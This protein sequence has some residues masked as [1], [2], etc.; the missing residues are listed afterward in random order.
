MAY[1]FDVVHRLEPVHHYADLR[2]GL[3]AGVADP[4]WFLGRQW[5]LGEH[6][7]ED[8]SSPVHVEYRASLTPINPFDRNERLDPQRVPAEAIV[9]GEPGEFWTPGRRVTIGRAVALAAAEAGRPP[10]ADEERL[11][12]SGLP[13]PY[14]VLDGTGFDG[15]ALFARRRDLELDDEWFPERPPRPAPRDLWDSA[16][17]VYSADFT[18]GQT[19]LSLRRHDGG[20]LDWWSVD[21]TAPIP[22]PGRP[23][24]PARV[25]ATRIRYPGAPNPRWWQ[26]EESRTDLGTYAPDRSHFATLLLL[27]LVTSHSDDWFTFPVAAAAGHVV[28][29]HEVVVVDDFGDRW[30]LEPPSD[31]WSLFA[32]TGLGPN[33]LVLWPSVTTPL[34]GPVLDQ[35]DLGVDEDANLVWAVE[36]RVDGRDNPTPE[37]PPEPVASAAADQDAQP[38]YAYRAS[39]EV[40]TFWHPYLIEDVG[41]RRRLVQCRLADLSGPTARPMPAPES[42]LLRDPA[43]GGRHPVHQL[44][45]SAVPTDGLQL[46]RCYVLGRGTDGQPVL[47]TQRR[48]LPLAIPPTMRLGFDMLEPA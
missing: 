4:V 1:R 11:L 27:E 15:R 19:G 30:T 38:R 22:P 24:E 5:Q 44:E 16:E 2:G 25:L 43:S 23:P 13:V 29:L 10:P 9:E 39:T 21:A 17:L 35:V 31:G 46:E 47:W 14:D 42:D 34:T 40:P 28:T 26:I 41:G 20:Y 8:A 33:S 48:R 32:V 18:A 45:P 36:R 3:A 6:Q 37:R 7:G 12:L